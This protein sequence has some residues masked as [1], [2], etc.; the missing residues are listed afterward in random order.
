[1][2]RAIILMLD[3]FGVG[4]AKDADKYGDVGA[5]TFGHIIKAYPDIKVPNMAKMGLVNILKNSSKEDFN[6]KIEQNPI[7]HYGYAIETSNGKDTPS[8]HWELMGC[9]VS[10]DWGY[11]RDEN[12]PFSKELL[13]KILSKAGLKGSLGNSIASGTAIIEDFGEEHIKTG[14]PIFYTSTDS[15]FQI[16]CHEETFGLD[17]L[18]NLCK[19][20][21]EE[22][23]DYN[24]GRV[25]ARPFLGD[26]KATFKRT[27]NRKDYSINPPSETLLDVMKNNKGQV[28]SIGKISDIFA[29]NGI[30]KAVKSSTLPNLVDDT[31]KQVKEVKDYSIIFTNFVDFDSEYGHRRD[32]KGYKEALEYFDSRLPEILAHVGED[33]LVVLLADHGNDPTWKGTDHTREHVPVIFYNKKLGGKDIGVLNTF[34]DV[35]QTIATYLGLPK[36]KHGSSFLK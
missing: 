36:L 15:V 10:F 18:Y 19:I 23:Y 16:A 33:D 13:E 35:G 21:R 30:T 14:F 27:G 34:A 2:K 22:L 11:F 3:S 4:Y 5:N 20:A 17:N 31:I 9:P 8:G 24:I 6:L 26:N 32:V 28:V 1:M 12:T 7:A 29:G 25:I